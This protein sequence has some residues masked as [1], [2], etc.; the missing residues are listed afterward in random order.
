M[1]ITSNILASPSFNESV[2]A[3]LLSREFLESKRYQDLE[4]LAVPLYD[5]G[6]QLSGLLRVFCPNKI[7]DEMCSLY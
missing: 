7:T 4:M 5:S 1:I 3:P 6:G 2:D